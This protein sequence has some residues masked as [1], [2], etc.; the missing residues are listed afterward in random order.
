M[1]NAEQLVE[2][3]TVTSFSSQPFLDYLDDKLERLRGL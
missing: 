3:V 2:Q 1:V